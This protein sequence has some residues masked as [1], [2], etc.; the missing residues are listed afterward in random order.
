[1]RVLSKSGKLE[2]VD[3]N[4]I[5]SR[6]TALC[7]LHSESLRPLS[8]HVDVDKVAQ[9]TIKMMI[10]GISTTELDEIA[11]NYCA[12]SVTVDVDYGKLA[13]RIVVDNLHRRTHRDYYDA[14]M[15]MR[16]YTPGT[17]AGSGS[18]Q[19]LDDKMCAFVGRYRAELAAV[20]LPL[21]VNDYKYDYFGIKT[22]MKS[23]LIKHSAGDGSSDV[24]IMERPQHM[25]MRVAIGIHFKWIDP[26]GD[27]PAGVLSDVLKT[28]TLLS[29]K[30][31]THATPTLFNAG[32]CRQALSSCFLLS[33]DDTIEDIYGT[34]A[35]TAYIS[36]WSGGIGIHVSQVRAKNAIIKSTNGFTEGIVPML[37]MFNKS[38]LFISQGGNKRR[39]STAVYLEMWH[40]DVFDFLD[41]KKPLGDENLRARDLFL[42]LWVCDVFMTRLEK[43]IHSKVTDDPV[44]W[45][46]FCPSKAP[47]LADVYGD[48]Y[49]ELYLRYE[50]EG[51]FNAQVEIQELW[52]AVLSLQMES[53]VPYISFKDHVNRKS[54]Q[55]NLGTIKSSNLCVHPTTKV[56]TSSGWLEI[57]TLE[58][59]KVSVW[60]GKQWSQVQVV[61]TSE[62]A[63]FLRVKTSNGCELVCTPEH[64]FHIQVRMPGVNECS[65]LEVPAMGLMPGD[66]LESFEL[67]SIDDITMSA[68]GHSCGFSDNE[69]NPTSEMAWSHGFKLGNCSVLGW[70]IPLQHEQ[71]NMLSSMPDVDMVLSSFHHKKTLLNNL[72]HTSYWEDNHGNM[73]FVLSEYLS[74]EEYVNMPKEIKLS[75]IAG[76]IDAC[77]KINSNPA[78]S[79]CLEIPHSQYSDIQNIVLMLQS[80]GIAPRVKHVP[81]SIHV[82]LNTWDTYHIFAVHKVPVKML[83]PDGFVMYIKPPLTMSQSGLN[84]VTIV[85]VE[86]FT[87]SQ[88][89]LDSNHGDKTP[90]FCFTEPIR[91]R[92]MF[93]GIITGQCNEINIYTDKDNVGVCNLA[94]VCLSKFVN[95]KTTPPSMDY[96]ALHE[97]VGHAVA[98]LNKVID[99]NVYPVQEA[100]DSDKKNRPIGLGVQSLAKT[101]HILN[102]PFTS[103]EAKEINKKIFET[104]YHAAVSKSCDL[105]IEYGTYESYQGSHMQQG[106]MQF[107]LWGVTPSK[108]WDWDSLRDR[109]QQ[110]GV[111]NS[112]LIALMPTA[113]TAQIMGNSESFE[114]VTSNMYLRTTLSGTFQVI[115]KYLIK[116]LQSRGLWSESTKTDI[117]RNNGSVHGLDYI[118]EDVK[119]VF[120]TVWEIKQKDLIDM[121]ADRNAYVCQS[122]SSNRY[123]AKPTI[124]KLKAMHLYC[125]KKG[126]KTGMYYL[127]S[128]A[129]ADAIK[130]T[131][132][133]AG[134]GQPSATEINITSNPTNAWDQ[135]PCETCSA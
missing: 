16:E 57:Q 107:D 42:A 98:G 101:F 8:Q 130:F 108:L 66:K 30:M 131:V 58:G 93:N 59:Q 25:C 115:N 132:S 31:Y 119:A 50:R 13:S 97:V 116:A 129:A 71:S 32:T 125:W 87:P 114:P 112:L 26:S 38:S 51:R 105:A 106:R 6:L 95:K 62:D 73:H 35:K 135:E 63:K 65:S 11:A 74:S 102:I 2:E 40:A 47:G 33:V 110:H 21:Y 104:I 79:L 43:S 1:M 10:D 126:L 123:L 4:K 83:K 124:G 77:G 118:P 100:F 54:N 103:P 85:S 88:H 9:H 7:N 69:Q 70:S 76:V 89:A 5:T 117:L 127:R 86:P 94:S 92:A 24:V 23:Y 64:K 67:P 68:S 41:L 82:L 78:P 34:L 72:T 19:L 36:K 20:M 111:R 49:R 113:S 133:S 61:K 56:L 44:M 99:N 55:S 91:H 48:E 29:N 15:A 12:G 109:V 46:L 122:T 45:S 81:H 128:K 96:S 90:S 28:Y 75:W 22:L 14:V 120:A 134:R 3:F 60:N 121:E 27:C 80:I 39:G 52:N 17:R 84:S 18:I 53:G 37:G